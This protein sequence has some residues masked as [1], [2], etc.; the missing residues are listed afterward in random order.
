MESN[1]SIDCAKTLYFPERQK[2][3]EPIVAK[4]TNVKLPAFF[5]YAKDKKPHQV[6]ERNK[7]FVNMIY[8]KIPNIRLDFRGI[9]NVD[10]FSYH[11]LM[12]N[13]VSEVPEEVISIYEENNNLYKYKIN[14]NDEYTPNLRFISLEIKKKFNDLG[15]NDKD[16]TN[17]LV[18]YVYGNKLRN[19]QLLWFCY[20]DDIYENICNNLKIENKPFKTI[21]CI[22]CGEYFDIPEKS[23]KACRCNACQKEYRKLY[24]RKRKKRTP[25]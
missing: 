23:F 13:N 24:D 15:Y 16:I 2:F 8:D 22:D 9:K 11:M 5:E 20:G 10:K 21:Q 3:F 19:K 4:Y 6:Q 17:I 12:S 18:K 14:H 7:S 25:E 1:F